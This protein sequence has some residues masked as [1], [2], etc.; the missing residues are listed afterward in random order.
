MGHLADQPKVCWA[1]HGHLL[2]KGF[3]G[4]VMGQPTDLPVAYQPTLQVS[5]ADRKVCWAC[6]GSP[7]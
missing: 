3:V 6:R 5:S 4:L 1:C 7:C 2:T